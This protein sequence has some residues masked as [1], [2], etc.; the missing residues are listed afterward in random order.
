MSMVVEGEEDESILTK[1]E[2]SVRYEPN[3]R[4]S[5]TGQ[6]ESVLKSMKKCN[7]V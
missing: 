7:V 2:R 3:P 1:D 5:I 4:D 6:T